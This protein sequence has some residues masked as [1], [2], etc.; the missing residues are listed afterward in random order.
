[1]NVFPEPAPCTAT[2]QPL[3][4]T[5]VRHWNQSEDKLTRQSQQ[6][7]V[8]RINSYPAVL[9]NDQSERLVEPTIVSFAMKQAATEVI[10]LIVI[11]LN[12]KEN[13]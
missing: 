5:S 10:Q 9:S 12:E 3:L 13:T 2:R 8:N 7:K 6:N 1:M 11:I 4:T